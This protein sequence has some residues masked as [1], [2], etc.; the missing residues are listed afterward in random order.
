MLE[1]TQVPGTRYQ[2]FQIKPEGKKNQKQN[3]NTTKQK[4]KER[5]RKKLKSEDS[6]SRKFSEVGF[7]EE[8]Q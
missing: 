3:Q 2:D 5:E 7:Y 6:Y 8:H 4:R 1:E